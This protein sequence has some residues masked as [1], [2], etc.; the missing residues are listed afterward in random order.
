MI[1][2]KAIAAVS[3]N[4]GL[5][6]DNALLFNISEDMR[7]FRSTTTDSVVIMGRKTL[8]SFPGG[9]PLP[10][11]VNIVLTRSEGYSKDGAIIVHSP[12][13]AMSEAKKYG[14]E[15]FVIGGAEIYALMLDLCD[16]CLITKVAACPEADSFFP[17][18][19]ENPAWQLAEASEEKEEN[20]VKFRFTSYRRK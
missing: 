17:N 1:I 9:K 13:E 11:R 15:I 16:E 20:G 6:K 18:L 19:D 7:F 4:W 3:Q 12:E 10:K 2:M 14:K 5:G 8:E